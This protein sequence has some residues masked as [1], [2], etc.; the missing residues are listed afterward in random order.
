V[1]QAPPLQCDLKFHSCV[2]LGLGVGSST[3][4][5]DS[6]VNLLMFPF[7]AQLLVLFVYKS[8]IAIGT[9][10]VCGVPLM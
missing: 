7:L 10:S 9:V 5:V 2:G 3:E 6:I 1:P 4:R 8:C